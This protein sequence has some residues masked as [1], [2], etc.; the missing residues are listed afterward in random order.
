MS[1]RNA[2]LTP[3]GRCAQRGDPGEVRSGRVTCKADRRSAARAVARRPRCICWSMGEPAAGS[4]GHCWQRQRLDRVRVG[5][6]PFARVR[7]G[8][9]RPRTRPDALPGARATPSAASMPGCAVAA[10]PRSRDQRASRARMGGCEG[11]PPAFDAEPLQAPQ[12]NAA[13]LATGRIASS[14]VG[15]ARGAAAAKGPSASPL[16]PAARPVER[17]FTGSS[18][19]APSPPATAAAYCWPASSSGSAT[20]NCRIRPNGRF[21]SCP[22]RRKRRHSVSCCRG[23]T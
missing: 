5:D 14:A 12:Q 20:T 16:R 10:S 6:G 13:R 18:S 17:R 8:G 21:S 2:S 23:F 9:R 19:S 3:T 11:R 7:P 1:H 15:R 22:Y 4:A